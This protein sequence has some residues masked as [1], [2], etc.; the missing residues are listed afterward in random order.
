MVPVKKP[1]TGPEKNKI[2]LT[3]IVNWTVYIR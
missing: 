1:R 3:L 2:Q